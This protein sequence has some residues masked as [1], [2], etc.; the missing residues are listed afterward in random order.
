MNAEIE[1]PDRKTY[2][3]PEENILTFEAKSY[4]FKVLDKNRFELIPVQTGTNGNGWTEIIEPEQL[5]GVNIVQ[6]GAYTL[7]M[8]LKNKAEE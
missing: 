4:V 3:L 5:Q 7:L 1:M 2:A 8:T 6:Q